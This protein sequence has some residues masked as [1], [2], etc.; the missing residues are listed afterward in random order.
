MKYVIFLILGLVSIVIALLL[1]KAN[2]PLFTSDDFQGAGKIGNVT[3]SGSGNYSYNLEVTHEGK[4]YPGH[5]VDYART[6]GKY[7]TGNVVPIRYVVMKNSHVFAEIVD[8]EL[9]TVRQKHAGAS[10]RMFA[11]G[12]GLIS[13]FAVLTVLACLRGA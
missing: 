3:V 5:T 7:K 4:V 6:N 10:T 11:L 2:A 13:L 9:V 12:I 1:K 8:D